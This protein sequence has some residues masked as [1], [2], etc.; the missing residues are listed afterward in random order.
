MTTLAGKQTPI[1]AQTCRLLTCGDP[2]DVGGRYSRM[3]SR[4]VIRLPIGVHC[5]AGI[6]LT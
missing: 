6:G 1:V 3:A 2:A 5:C 4:R